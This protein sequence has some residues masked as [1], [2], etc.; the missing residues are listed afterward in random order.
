VGVGWG[1]WANSAAVVPQ[2]RI[3]CWDG[4]KTWGYGRIRIASAATG[5]KADAYHLFCKE[6]P[7]GPVVE[8]NA[9][10]SAK[11]KKRSAASSGPPAKLVW[12]QED[13][14]IVRAMVK[15]GD[16]LVVA[17]PP[18][19]GQKDSEVLQFRNEPEALA[20]YLGKK[21]V[22]LRVISAKDGRKISECALDAMPVFDGMSAAG[23]RIYLS[24]NNGVLECRGQ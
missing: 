7:A 2:G 17:G 4:E 22:F 13:S 16:T 14:L 15:V 23:G 18:D 12:S 19:L 9:G 8:T 11:G 10:S 3:L 24:L 1:G 6:K 20:G 5:H 21:G